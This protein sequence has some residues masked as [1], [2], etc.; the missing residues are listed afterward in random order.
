MAIAVKQLPTWGRRLLKALPH[1]QHHRSAALL[2]HVPDA[3]GAIVGTRQQQVRLVRVEGYVVYGPLMAFQH[4]TR[5][6]HL[7][8]TLQPNQAVCIMCALTSPDS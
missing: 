6:P 8:V 7:R 4:S 5:L 3:A 2:Q 1:V